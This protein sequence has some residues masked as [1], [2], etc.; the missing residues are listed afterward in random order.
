MTQENTEAS[1]CGLTAAAYSHPSNKERIV[2]YCLL[3]VDR[4][5]DYLASNYGSNQFTSQTVNN[6]FPKTWVLPEPGV[7]ME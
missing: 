1:R 5:I 6:T 7:I 3:D 2:R 4:S